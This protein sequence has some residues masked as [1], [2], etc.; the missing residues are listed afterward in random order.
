MSLLLR[1]FGARVDV[2][3]SSG[4]GLKNLR[5][6]RGWTFLVRVPVVLDVAAV[7]EDPWGGTLVLRAHCCLF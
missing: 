4:R 5:G 2:R 6:S 1:L 3:S 7:A